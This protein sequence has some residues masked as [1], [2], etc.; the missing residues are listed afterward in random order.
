LCA[1]GDDMIDIQDIR[2]AVETI[3]RRLP[4]KRLGLF[5]SAVRDDFAARSDVDVLVVFDSRPD[6]D[7]FDSYFELK[8]QLEGLFERPVDLTVDKDFRNPVFREAVD[9]SR[10]V[11]YER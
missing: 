11:I 8:E 9:K 1:A 7:L 6:V 2:P 10:V 5:G 3:C 4:V